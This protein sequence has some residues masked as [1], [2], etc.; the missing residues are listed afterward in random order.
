MYDIDGVYCVWQNEYS[1]A[2]N[3]VDIS[4]N[5]FVEGD[6]GLYE[7]ME[8]GFREIALPQEKITQLLEK[9]GFDVLEVREYLTDRQPAADSDKLMF[10]ARKK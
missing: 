10:A 7:R 2:D 4:L 1:P 6:D 9:S 8:E 3:G 5:I